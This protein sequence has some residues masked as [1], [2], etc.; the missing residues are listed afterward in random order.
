ML[1]AGL[2]PAG[3][4]SL[5]TSRHEGGLP[6]VSVEQTNL[7]SISL[8][9]GAEP[10][11]GYRLLK[12]LGGG[13]FGEVWEA[14]GPGG[15]HVALKFVPL[16]ERAGAV[17]LRSLEIL[18]GIHH[19]NLLVTFGAWQSKGYL[20]I[21]M[22]L[23]DRTLWDRFQEAVGQGLPGIPREELH[24]YILEAAKGID[25]LNAQKHVFEGESGI[26]VQH[27]DIKPQN[28]LLVGGGVKV[29]D[30]GLARFLKHAVTQHTGCLT[31]AYAAPEFF[32][33]QTSNHSDQYSLAAT[34]CHLRGG[35]P[36]HHGTAS[37]VMFGHLNGIPDLTALPE[38]ERSSV[39]RALAKEPAQR[40]PSCRAFAEALRGSPAA[41]GHPT[42]VPV[43][44]ARSSEEAPQTCQPVAL[45]AVAVDT[46]PAHEPR[47]ETTPSAGRNVRV[48]FVLTLVLILGLA[49]GAVAI[50][51]PIKLGP[52]PIG[53][54]T[55]R[56][57]QAAGDPDPERPVTV[58]P[59]RSDAK[60]ESAAGKPTDKPSRLRIDVPAT[61]GLRAG[62]RRRFEV[63]LLREELTGPVGIHLEELPPGLAAT[64]ATVPD[65][66]SAA[67]VEIVAA[68]DATE[69]SKPIKLIASAGPIRAEAV[70]HL[71]VQP[72]ATL[73][74]VD[75]P[76]T[77][78]VPAGKETAFTVKIHRDAFEG[79]VVMRFPDL[80]KG[81]TIE[82]VTVPAKEGSAVLKAVA[83]EDAA[84]TE[85]LL[86]GVAAATTAK[87]EADLSLAVKVVSAPLHRK[88]GDSL[89]D[90]FEYKQAIVE[91]TAPL[92]IDPADTVAL[93][94]RGW[95]YS[96]SDQQSQAIADYDEVI[97]IR[98]DYARA[99]RDRGTAYRLKGNYERAIKDCTEAIRLDP[100]D[101]AGFANRAEAYHH[102]GEKDRAIADC[103]AAIRLK[104][105]DAVLYAN[106]GFF[107]TE[108]RQFDPAL[109]DFEEALKLKPNYPI[110]YKN[111]G[112]LYF[113][114]G[115]HDKAITE[116][117]T[118]IHLDPA[119]A[120]AYNG[121]ALAY[122]AQCEYGR[123]LADYEEALRLS[124]DAIIYC[125]RAETHVAMNNYDRA[126][127]DYDQALRL[128]PRNARAHNDRGYTF[129]LQKDYA[130]A[131]ADYTEAINISPK[132]TLAY[133]NRAT[134]HAELREYDQAIADFSEAIR[135][136]PKS[137]AAYNGR[138]SAYR[139]KGDLAH[140]LAEYTQSLHINPKLGA[141]HNLK[142]GVHLRR[143]E[144]DHCIDEANQA[145]RLEPKNAEAWNC[146][147]AAYSWK[148]DFDSAI[149]DYTK[150]IELSPRYAKPYENRALAYQAKGL[151]DKAKADLA[152]YHQLTSK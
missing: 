151:A 12:R 93:V 85:T 88:R 137:V 16:G 130:K 138:G 57:G 63:H 27:R 45:A 43:P 123:A 89:A 100:N 75:S 91:Y 94:S 102:K 108:K 125:N 116:A 26:G 98:P 25:H 40:W 112:Y 1:R 68:D 84:E 148:G 146:R 66:G 149:R 59:S 109:A 117:S 104:S 141:T 2:A 46:L 33:G 56:A 28:I 18:K 37:E 74:I 50:W 44:S 36:P 71:T 69:V 107:Y 14:E 23:A 124:K 136:N 21:A 29:A 34:Y 9:A 52:V 119:Y 96:K 10:A 128:N 49:V 78:L 11:A 64:E 97:R 24:E 17:E 4:P 127:A 118:A 42:P 92:R 51:H 8:T 115:K 80:P 81:V 58:K 67:N 54:V 103:T 72:K 19:P 13:G 82:Q 114:M 20:V 6:L 47:T 70:L 135:L 95:A 152:K 53:S 120:A 39:A 106:R 105:R 55:P 60:T 145:I 129:A 31:P 79:P 139:D 76:G 77:L 99:Y 32:R 61:V 143:K 30:F 41:A 131:I 122:H 73:R 101:A 48:W 87:A 121:R 22:E 132:Y 5:Q 3:A 90:K 65:S 111:R 150:A 15:F 38:E 144:Y 83:D 7:G 62:E 113:L 142:A 110:V 35:N 133:R 86:H 126:L 147:G 140:A 134:S